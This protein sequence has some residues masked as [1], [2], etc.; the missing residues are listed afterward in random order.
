[1]CPQTRTRRREPR[2]H[3]RIWQDRCVDKNLK[4]EWLIRLNDLQA[5]DLIS[6]CGGHIKP[7][8]NPH[9]NLRLKKECFP[10]VSDKWHHSGRIM[11]RLI[12]S[13]FS[14][15]HS[16]VEIEL[17]DVFRRWNGRY[18]WRQDLT[19]RIRCSQAGMPKSMKSGIKTWF[20]TVIG[21]IKELDKFFVDM[22]RDLKT[23]NSKTK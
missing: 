17:K 5:F 2:P 23:S 4:D 8:R 1:M 14:S 18:T 19:T 11:S 12:D 9:I 7:T 3:E 6:I 16:V 15:E 21:E 13:I 20:E 22:Y 10:A